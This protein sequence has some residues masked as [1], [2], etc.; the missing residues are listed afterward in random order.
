MLPTFCEIAGVELPKSY[1]P[2]GVSQLKT[3]MGEGTAKRDTPL[4]WKYPARWPPRESKPD[5]WVALAVAH[6]NW[7]LVTNSDSTHSELYDL[8][9]DPYEATDLSASKPDVVKSLLEKLETWKSTLPKKPTGNVFSS[10][11]SEIKK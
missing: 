4:F 6:E 11:R 7:K 2:D 5:H 10:L 9:A 3:L 1:S 8:V